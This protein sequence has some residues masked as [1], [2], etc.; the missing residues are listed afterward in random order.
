MTPLGYKKT[1]M[2]EADDIKKLTDEMISEMVSIGMTTQEEADRLKK[3]AE[4][5][6]KMDMLLEPTDEEKRDFFDEINCR[7]SKNHKCRFC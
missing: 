6:A 1:I 3:E 5:D 2:E 4:I 7:E